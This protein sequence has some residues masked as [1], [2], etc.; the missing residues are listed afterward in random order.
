MIPK[1]SS[2]SNTKNLSAPRETSFP[3]Y[4]P[5]STTCPFDKSV[6]SLL[7]A[8]TSPCEGFSVALSGMIIPEAVV[9]ASSTLFY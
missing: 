9:F 4:L 8:T 3:E 5:K 7:T 6:T 1:I 2:V